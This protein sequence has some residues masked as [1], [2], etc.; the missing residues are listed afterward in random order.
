M[1]DEAQQADAAEPQPVISN[2]RRNRLFLIVAIVVAVIAVLWF[3]YNFFIGS[4]SVSTDNAYVAG[5]VAQVTAE[6]GGTVATVDVIDTQTVRRGQILYRLDARDQLIALK[7]GQAGVAYA[8]RMYEQDLAKNLAL[9]AASDAQDA[10][11]S[12]AAAQAKAAEAALVKARADYGRRSA[13]AGTGAVSAE[14]LSSAREA[15]AKAQ[16]D[17]DAMRAGL[18]QARSEA[19]NAQQQQRASAAITRGTTVENAPSVL[20]AKSQLAKSQLDYERT[21]VRAP[22]DGVIVQR[23]IEVGQSIEKGAVA[24]RIVPMAQLYVQANYKE[25]Q[26]G[27]VRVGQKARLKSDLYGGDVVYHGTVVGFSG[28]TGSAFS[29]IPAQNATGNWIKVVQRLPVRIRLDPAELKKHPLRVGLSME[30]EI[31]I[32]DPD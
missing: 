8:K 18:S 19:V 23:A 21:L 6:T 9:G 17:L 25:N 14:D 28:G 32:S 22:M 2:G 20:L 31:D 1:S 15:L 30:A 3:A 4:R 12:T 26:L 7:Q 16:A 13:L 11:I 24:M 27:K 10:A 29:L 5:D